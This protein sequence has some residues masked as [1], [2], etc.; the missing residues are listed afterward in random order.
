MCWTSAGKRE[1]EA[2]EQDVDGIP[3]ARHFVLVSEIPA[4]KPSWPH[5]GYSV[6]TRAK[7]GLGFR[8]VVYG[9]P[10]GPKLCPNM[11]THLHTTLDLRE[12]VRGL[13]CLSFCDA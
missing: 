2:T 8:W 5:A 3:R 7:L 12:Y 9:V 4:S 6:D 1:R 11:R 13:N 10:N